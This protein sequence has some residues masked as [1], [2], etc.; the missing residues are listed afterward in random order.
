MTQPR[1]AVLGGGLAGLSA[2]L[3]LASRGA[4]VVLFERRPAVGGKA[5]ELRLDGFRFDTGPTVVTLPDVLRS[6]F[7]EAGVGAPPVVEPLD[8]LCRYHFPSGRVWDVGR[9]PDRTAAQLP[10]GQARVFTVLLE[11][12]RALF[13]GAAPTF[14]YGP[15]P[16]PAALLRYALLHGLK[17]HPFETMAGR[18]RRWGAD[19]ELEA[20]FLRFATYAGADPYRAPAVLLNIAWAELGLGAVWLRGG[21][22]GLV[23]ALERALVEAGA[24]VHTGVEVEGVVV[25]GGRARAVHAGGRR[26]DV[27][28]VVSAVDIELTRRWLGR[29]SGRRRAEPSTSGFVLLLGVEGRH[30]DG[31][32]HTVIFPRDYAA[33]SGA[34]RGGRLA[35]EPTLYVSVS[36]R[37]DPADAPD[38][39][40]NWFVMA[41]APALPRE[42]AS[43]ALAAAVPF[44]TA[45]P[46]PGLPTL[47]D[48]DGTAVTDGEQRYADHL[49]RELER[50]AGFDPRRV[51]SWRLLGP[52]QL[53][54]FGDRGSLYGAAPAGLTGALRPAPRF[55]G[56]AGLALAGGTVHPGGGIPLV[57]LSG[58]HAAD[59]I[60]AE[61]R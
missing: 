15:K 31:A 61:R 43:D 53:A 50:R 45:P 41:N 3:R 8:P 12:A 51:R 16:G 2:A 39:H 42:P 46:V 55:Q 37:S 19:P 48:V 33:E 4:E 11:E 54:A 13:E 23:S 57:L 47:L 1:V 49:L 35:L 59:A 28:A 6:T 18:V 56:V 5:S 7:E 44:A 40:E 32:H 34:L 10:P 9:D 26:W 36:A 25:E 29:A 22:Y 60:L 38:G 20:F 14:V 27:D 58:R 21:V 30:T 17:A 24:R 52:R